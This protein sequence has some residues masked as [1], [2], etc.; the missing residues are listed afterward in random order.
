MLV[1]GVEFSWASLRFA[2]LGNAD[3]KGVQSISYKRARE[4]S[5]LYGAGDEPVARSRGNVT[6]E[7]EIKLMQKE[8]RAIREAAAGKPLDEIGP[9]NIVIQ[10]SNG[11]DPIT[12]DE[13]ENVEFLEDGMSG[14]Q[15]AAELP[16]TIPIIIGG[17][18]LGV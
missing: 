3:V 15:G 5:N 9:F 17:I 8:V 16:V 1:N 13:L 4:K 2:F 14:E 7:G 11:T 6:Y 12:S 10:Y 18:K